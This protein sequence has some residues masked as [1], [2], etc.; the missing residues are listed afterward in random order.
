MTSTVILVLIAGIGGLVFLLLALQWWRARRLLAQLPKEEPKYAALV[1]DARVEEGERPSSL[2]AE[3]IEEMV[4]ASLAA[5]PELASVRFDLG[6]APNGSLEIWIDEHAYTSVGDIPD[7]RIRQ[8][9]ESAVEE[10]NR[11]AAG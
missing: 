8:A 4:K 11:R 7:P 9:I 3:Q 1:A 10:W 2:V 6:T 5:D